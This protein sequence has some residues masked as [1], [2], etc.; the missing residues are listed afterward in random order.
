[1]MDYQGFWLGFVLLFGVL[2]VVFGAGAAW[3]GRG[4]PGGAALA[5]F[6]R[7]CSAGLA[8]G[9]LSLFPPFCSFAPDRYAPLIKRA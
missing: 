9:S 8:R 1:M 7:S 6:S 3:S 5:W 4:A 2:S